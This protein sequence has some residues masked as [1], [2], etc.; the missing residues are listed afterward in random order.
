ML[1]GRVGDDAV[2]LARVDN[3]FFAVGATCTHY[4]GPL[5]EGLLVGDTV[6]CP[7]HHACFSLRTGAARCPPALSDLPRWR[8]EVLDGMVFVREKLPLQ[9]R[10]PAIV[11]R[12]AASIVIL[13]A[14]AA[15]T[16]AADTLRREGF[17]GRVALVD[18]DADAP[19]D[20][21]NLSKDYLAGTIPDDYLPLHPPSYY[22]DQRIELLTGRTAKSIDV[23][24]KRVLLADGTLLPFDRLLIATGA[25]PVVLDL[26][27]PDGRKIHYLRTLQDCQ[28]IIRSA[29]GSKRA[30]VLGTSFIGLEV[31]ASLRTRGLE[32]HIVGPDTL[33]LGRILGPELGTF[34][35]DLHQEKGVVFHLGHT[36]KEWNARGVILDDGTPLAADLVVAGVG[37][38]PNLQLAK[39]AGLA[40]DGG[41]LVDEGLETSAADIFAAGDAASWIEPRT[42]ERVRVEHWV[43]AERM[44]QH[45]ARSMLGERKPFDAV[46]FFWSQ[47]YD[48]PINYVGYGGRWDKAVLEGDPAARDC[49]VTYYRGGRAVALATIYRDQQSLATELEMERMLVP[50]NQDG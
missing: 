13:G 10:A 50:A 37:V 42:G 28:H 30:V 23:S 27:V 21:P 22:A 16:T 3:E 17:Q 40:V 35:R 43:V 29:A 47:H 1:A 20:R 8:V 18:P 15:G 41:I 2:L 26:P 38:R 12:D 34:I 7:W 9:E 48:V 25:A 19:Y 4:S 44:G 45:A 49:A 46:P 5:A 39:Q 24:G 36:A 14:G 6:R 32:V 11:G 31:A 33:P